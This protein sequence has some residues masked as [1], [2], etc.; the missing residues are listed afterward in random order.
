MDGHTMNQ[1]TGIF[2]WI[3]ENI[4]TVVVFL[5]AL[6]AAVL[7][8]MPRRDNVIKWFAL[9]LAIFTFIISLHLPVHFTSGLHNYQFEI[10]APWIGSPEL[11]GQS[12]GLPTIIYHIGIDG[13][14][15]WLVI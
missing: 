4:L 7:A 5:P 13:I 6:G 3:V 11:S 10:Y 12:S 1:H 9:G 8:F 14:S 15:L 2:G